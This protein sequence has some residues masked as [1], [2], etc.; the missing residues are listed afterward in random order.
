MSHA[1][2]LVYEQ[3]NRNCSLLY[4]HLSITIEES[5][6]TPREYWEYSVAENTL[7]TPS[8]CDFSELLNRNSSCS[9]KMFA[10]GEDILS[11][12]SRKWESNQNST[13]ESLPNLSDHA[14]FML[15]NVENVSRMESAD[16]FSIFLLNSNYHQASAIATTITLIFYLILNAPIFH[17]SQLNFA[18]RIS[19]Q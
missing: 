12:G 6:L 5:P 1:S 11:I 15:P 16:F 3:I 19:V 9:L 18:V 10:I 17:Y 8:C 7:R 14:A 4:S 13:F 2:H